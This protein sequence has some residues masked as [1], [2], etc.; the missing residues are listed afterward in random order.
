[1]APWAVVSRL[2]LN[3]RLPT[4]SSPPYAPSLACQAVCGTLN[5]TLDANTV[6][7]VMAWC[8][9]TL[10]FW[11]MP[12]SCTKLPVTTV[13]RGM[14]PPRAS[15]PM[16]AGSS[17]EQLALTQRLVDPNAAIALSPSHENSFPSRSASRW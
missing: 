17:T 9:A 1:M 6:P 4:S 3:S 2:T 8:H 5:T 15:G 13:P 14:S 7:P 10:C 11:K 16:F 12:I